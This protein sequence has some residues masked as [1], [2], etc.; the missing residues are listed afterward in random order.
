M[1]NT[2]GNVLVVDDDKLICNLLQDVL[3]RNNVS[4]MT[5]LNG[6]EALSIINSSHS[7][8]MVL[9]DVNM[10]GMTGLTL[11]Q[12]IKGISPDLPVVVMTGFGTEQIAVKALL[13]GAYNFCR[14][15]FDINEITTIVKKGLDLRRNSMRE[16][17]VIPFLKVQLHFEIPSDIGFVRSIV[18]HIQRECGR[19][20]F[21]E[22][23]FLMRVKLALDEAL[24][25]AI[26]HGNKN[27]FSKAVGIKVE[28]STKK[29]TIE[30]TDQGSGFDISRVPDPLDPKNLLVEGGRGLLLMGLYMD[31]L[32]F[33]ENGTKVKMTKN[34]QS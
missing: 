11:M 20:G 23:V 19:L 14:K 5:A 12:R 27:D 8:D 28:I 33:N 22:D 25:N 30:I 13:A 1:V 16:K 4:T 7:I 24:A 29:I 31:S 2:S 9:T 6:E 10:P 15:P 17:E 34:A 26:K 21:P 3:M 32:E 18:N